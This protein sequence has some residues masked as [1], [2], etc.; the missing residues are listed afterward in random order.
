MIIPS[1][2]TVSP[3][4]TRMMSPTSTSSAGTTFSVSSEM[5][6]AVWGVRCTSFS[7]P[8]R[9]LATV[10]SSRRA[11]SCMMNATSPAAKSSPIITDA[12]SARETRTSAL[13]SN[14]VT[15]PIMA[16]N[17]I[18]RPQRMM[19]TQA[20]SKGSGAKWKMLII[21]AMPDSTR[22][23]MSFFVP[24]ISRKDSS[25]SIILIMHLFTYP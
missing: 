25:F 22:Q 14:A 10:I 13:M 8:A 1:T 18:G 17:T 11:P 15:R 3:G 2:G 20:A 23:G 9:A 7:I 21:K 6:R 12:I 5:I 4:R 16:S 24:P 19:A